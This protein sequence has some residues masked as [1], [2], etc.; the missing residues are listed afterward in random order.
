M[1]LIISTCKEKLNEKEFVL[2][3]QRI[4]GESFV[5]KYNEFTQEDIDKADEIIISGT[6]LYDFDYNN[7]LDKFNFL[8]TTTKKVIGICAGFQII[9]QIF[10]CEVIAKEIIGVLNVKTNKEF[11]AYFIHNNTLKI[12]NEFEVIGTVNND[13]CYI[14]HKTKDITG[15]AFH[16]EVYN[17][18]LLK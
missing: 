17:E 4:C 13:P 10:G 1:K 3:L 2:P 6:A 9:G 8:K 18:E 11:K 7:Y 12:N 14:K 5:R 15:F 16:P